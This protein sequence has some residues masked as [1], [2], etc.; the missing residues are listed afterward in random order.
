MQAVNPAPRATQDEAKVG[1]TS[2]VNGL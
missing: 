2:P 1:N